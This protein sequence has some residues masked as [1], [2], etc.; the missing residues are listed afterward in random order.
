M[1]VFDVAGTQ[2]Q[3]KPV[4]KA[5]KLDRRLV[6]PDLITSARGPRIVTF[7]L[8]SKTESVV[9]PTRRARPLPLPNLKHGMFFVSCLRLLHVATKEV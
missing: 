8:L 2:K 6:R 9:T 1:I 7:I 4:H 5:A 3:S